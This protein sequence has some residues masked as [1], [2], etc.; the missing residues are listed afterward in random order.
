M[1]NRTI[2]F[3]KFSLIIISV[4]CVGIFSFLALFMRKRSSDTISEVGNIYMSGMNNRITL[5]FATTM[6]FRLSHVEDLEKMISSG[7]YPDGARLRA[8]LAYNAQARGFKYVALYSMDEEFETIYGE[9]LNVVDPE[10]FFKS[11]T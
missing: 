3:L 7:R 6:E 11:L 8:E 1:K 2:R 10:S 4:L 9:P 5:H